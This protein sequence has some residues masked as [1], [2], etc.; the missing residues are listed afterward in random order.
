M[1]GDQISVF[2]LVQNRLLREALTG[3][4]EKDGDI[5][6]VGASVLSS[7]AAR[8]IESVAPRVLVMDTFASYLDFIRQALRARPDLKVVMI[9]MDADEFCF[10]QVVRTGAAGYIL[11]D[12][13][14]L[15]VIAAVRG[16]AGGEAVCPPQMCASLFRYVARQ[17]DQFPSLHIKMDLGLSN[18]EQ[19]LVQLMG[20]GLTNK[21]IAM[22]L[23]LAEQTV[24]NHVHRTLRKLGADNRLAAVE[25]CRLH[26]LAV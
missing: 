18:R 11:K 22:E 8:Q 6:V 23:H 21:Q 25:T 2:L 17:S 16:L 5:A 19:Q 3:V 26:G 9:G 12:A 14:N 13:S 1:T 24:R 15:E 4:L 7:D 20:R 10:L